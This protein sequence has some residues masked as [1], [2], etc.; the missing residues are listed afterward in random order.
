MMTSTYAQWPFRPVTARSIDE[1]ER[2]WDLC[3][4]PTEASRILA[5]WPHWRIIAGGPGSGKSV[6]LAEIERNEAAQS[7]VVRYP[8]DYWPN[9]KMT[10]VKDSN[11]LAQIMACSAIAIRD[12]LSGSPDKI[13]QLTHGQIVFLRW[14]LD[15]FIG[16]RA[17]GRWIDGLESELTEILQGTLYEDLYQSVTEPRDVHGQID[18]LIGLARRLGFRRVLVSFDLDSRRFRHRD[19]LGRLFDTLDLMHHA[20]LSLIAAVPTDALITCNLVERARGRVNVLYLDW[21]VAQ[22]QEI[23]DRYLRAATQDNTAK[24]EF[25]AESP[26][27]EHLESLLVTEFG[28]VA[29]QAWIILA[30]TVLHLA[31]RQSGRLL[32]PIS[33]SDQR[34][35]VETLFKRHIKL[36][37]IPG[38]GLWRGPR[39][40][41]LDP[42]P[43]HFIEV[44]WHHAHTPLGAYDTELRT[45]A[46]S[47]GN[48]HTLARRVRQTIEPNPSSPIYLR[49]DRG[50]GGYWLEN[51][52]Q[53]VEN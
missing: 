25:Y 13:R 21:S 12:Y 35:V 23:A 29:P 20:G 47:K 52:V 26:L 14:M 11:H 45:L 42:Q 36:E 8:T 30:E 28:S 17:F 43:L 4:L 44:L 32:P 39:F 16:M 7:L 24:L 49:N 53:S 22:V 3:Y 18:E 46:H 41:P 9:S 15:R 10:L 38:K 34:E 6:L 50:E 27:L 48:V 31:T 33:E 37:L 5:G 19:S 40:I 1:T 51:I 2:W